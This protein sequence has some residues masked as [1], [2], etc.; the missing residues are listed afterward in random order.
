MIVKVRDNL[1]IGDKDAYK[2]IGDLT[3]RKINRVV[4]V[5]DDLPPLSFQNSSIGIYI[6]GLRSDR[7]NAP[8]IKDL[9]CHVPKYMMQNGDVVLIQSRTGVERAAYVVCRVLCEIESKS[10]YELYLELKKDLPEFDIGK[11]YF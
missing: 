5:A 10:I 7:M 1:Y 11:A 2:E 6:I 4:C 8:H 3:E 9:A